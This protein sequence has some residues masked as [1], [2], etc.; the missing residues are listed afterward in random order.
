MK[1][2][3]LACVLL[4][5]AIILCSLAGMVLFAIQDWRPVAGQ[6]GLLAVTVA[7]L[8]VVSYLFVADNAKGLRCD[9]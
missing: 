6:L 4:L 3:R 5:A 8:W 9:A 1:F 7:L 2:I